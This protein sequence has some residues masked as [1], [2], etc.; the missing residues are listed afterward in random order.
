MV[1]RI[2]YNQKMNG[3]IT[4]VDVFGVSSIDYNMGIGSLYVYTDGDKEYPQA[5]RLED[6]ARLEI[7]N[8]AGQL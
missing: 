4:G 1:V 2:D 7:V 6:I 5:F 3:Y 8:E